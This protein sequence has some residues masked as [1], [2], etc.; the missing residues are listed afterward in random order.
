MYYIKKQSTNANLSLSTLGPTHLSCSSDSIA[1][2][3]SVTRAIVTGTLSFMHK[4][5]A[6]CCAL[7]KSPYT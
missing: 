3:L 4:Y 5:I 2:L 1:K 7:L 6:V